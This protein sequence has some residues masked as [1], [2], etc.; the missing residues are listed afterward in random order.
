MVDGTVL[1]FLTGAQAVRVPHSLLGC[2]AAVFKGSPE[3]SAPTL[4]CTTAMARVGSRNDGTLWGGSKGVTVVGVG[5][6]SV[7]KIRRHACGDD[8]SG[9]R[10]RGVPM[11]G[12]WS[13]TGARI[14]S[15]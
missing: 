4:G 15:V 14:C 10:A 5:V 6:G 9:G 7:R 11:S 12:Y 1:V 8:C 13:H 2:G 3:L